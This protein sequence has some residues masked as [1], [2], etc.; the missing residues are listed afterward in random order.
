MAEQKK[1]KNAPGSCGKRKQFFAHYFG[2]VRPER[3]LRHLL[4][5]NGVHAAKAWAEAHDKLALLR[6]IRGIEA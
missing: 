1:K 6:Q 5:R 3:K 4:K 2:S